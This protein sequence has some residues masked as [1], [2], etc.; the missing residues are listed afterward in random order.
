MVHN[1]WDKHNM[2]FH[3]SIPS[4]SVGQFKWLHWFLS[5][6]T[7]K[8]GVYFNDVPNLGVSLQVEDGRR[9]LTKRPL[10][11]NSNDYDGI[12]LQIENLTS[13]KYFEF[14]FTLSETINFQNCN[15]YPTE[16]YTTYNECDIDF[17]YNEMKNKFMIMPFWA[18]KNLE[19]VTNHT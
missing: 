4:L 18:A 9:S 14:S 3:S 15:D 7:I 6:C 12:P 2:V 17:V 5:E 1:L 19:E 10:I 8:R 13:H 16:K 11:S